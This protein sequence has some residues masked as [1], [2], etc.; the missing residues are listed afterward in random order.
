MVIGTA[1][2]LKQHKAVPST[3]QD[4]TPY[5]GIQQGRGTKVLLCTG[6]LQQ[7]PWHFM[8]WESG[9]W[10]T[11]H[12]TAWGPVRAVNQPPNTRL[13]P[14]RLGTVL[15]PPPFLYHIS[16]LST[17][18]PGPHQQL[19]CPCSGGTQGGL[20]SNFASGHRVAQLGLVVD[21]GHQAQVGLDEDG[22]LQHQHPI[23]TSWHWALL[24]GFL[25]SLDQLSLKVFQLQEKKSP[26]FC[27]VLP[28]DKT[29]SCW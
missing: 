15:Q 17:L 6:G 28:T 24:V 19:T 12:T 26:C 5:T 7:V 23:G 14:Q 27:I 20:K 13:T 18:S 22:P 4:L 25:H 1:I 11:E 2:P 8:G 10:E 21:E 16:A 3:R 9:H 29:S